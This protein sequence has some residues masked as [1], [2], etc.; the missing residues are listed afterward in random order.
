MLHKLGNQDFL[1][2]ILLAD[3]CEL[4]KEM[5]PIAATTLKNW[6][7]LEKSQ[8][9]ALVTFG[10]RNG[11]ILVPRLWEHLVSAMQIQV[12]TCYKEM[13]SLRE[14]SSVVVLSL[15]MIFLTTLYTQTARTSAKIPNFSPDLSDWE[16]KILLLETSKKK[17]NP[18]DFKKMLRTL[19]DTGIF[20]VISG[21]LVGK[22]MDETF[23]DDYKEALLI[24][25]IAISRLSIIWMSDTQLQEQLSPFGVH[26]HVDATE[27]VIRFDYNKVRVGK[28]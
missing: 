8:K 22:P 6:L 27:Q 3:I 28:I 7:R 1:W 13:L 14:K 26:A 4:D 25:L 15:S 10:M 17:P 23:Y 24:S 12:L 18:E 9:F 2:A 19:K 11:L 5:L 20:E 21:L 16:R